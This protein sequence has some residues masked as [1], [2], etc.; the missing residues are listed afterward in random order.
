M[1]MDVNERPIEKLSIP[2]YPRLAMYLCVTG[3]VA[4]GVVSY[5]YEYI[6]SLS[7]GY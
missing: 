3:I 6:H 1:F 7:Y 4:T 2:I 5:I